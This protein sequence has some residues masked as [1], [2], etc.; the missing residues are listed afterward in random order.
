MPKLKLSTKQKGVLS[1]VALLLSVLFFAVLLLNKQNMENYISKIAKQSNTVESNLSTEAKLD[2]LY[3][4]TKNDKTLQFTFIEF[5]AKG[6]SACLRMETVMDEIRKNHGDKINVVFYNVLLPENQEYMTFYGVATIPT[7]ILLDSSGK[8]IF[9]HNG[10]ISM[11]EI[12]NIL[13]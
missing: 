2:E 12:E 6:C 9:R 13:F 5:G 8:E 11:K 7:Q 4:Y 10:F 1:V 3:N